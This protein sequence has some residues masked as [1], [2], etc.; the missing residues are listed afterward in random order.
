M[1]IERQT[2]G[3]VA[4]KQASHACLLLTYE[5]LAKQ[6][7]LAMTGIWSLVANRF[8]AQLVRRWSPVTSK[9]R[10]QQLDAVLV[11]SNL[12]IVYVA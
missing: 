10:G 1:Y 7:M 8:P 2:G 3:Q 11:W 6:A 5:K 12:D 4:C 9:T